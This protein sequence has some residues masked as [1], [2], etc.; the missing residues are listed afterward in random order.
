MLAGSTRPVPAKVAWCLNT[1]WLKGASENKCV[2]GLT[3][4][5]C[6]TLLLDSGPNLWDV[7][8]RPA[9]S[10]GE[11]LALAAGP[12]PGSSSEQGLPRLK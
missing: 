7:I 8:V 12:G 3:I 9:S 11:L 4:G 6:L 1:C 5:D 2:S 10:L